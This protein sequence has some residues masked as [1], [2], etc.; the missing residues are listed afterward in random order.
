MSQEKRGRKLRLARRREDDVIVKK[1]VYIEVS[2]GLATFN[3]SYELSE[4]MDSLDIDAVER[5]LELYMEAVPDELCSAIE[6]VRGILREKVEVLVPEE[7]LK[8]REGQIQAE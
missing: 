6:Y 8:S 4:Y 3:S 2:G 1:L 7:C 5:L